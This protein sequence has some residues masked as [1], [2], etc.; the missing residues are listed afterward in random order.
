MLVAPA[1]D[2]DDNE[3]LQLVQY[4][5]YLDSVGR[6]SAAAREALTEYE[7]TIGRPTRAGA[8]LKEQLSVDHRVLQLAHD[9]IAAEFRSFRKDLHPRPRWR[10]EEAYKYLLAVEWH[11]WLM[12][13]V[14]R[15]MR[16]DRLVRELCNAMAFANT[17][18]GREAEEYIRW[19]MRNSYSFCKGHDGPWNRRPAADLEPDQSFGPSE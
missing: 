16:D 7:R 6:I 12:S 10:S 13:Q 18:T 14:D 15:H 1:F 9:F 4:H 17:P 19:H 2:G 3:V 8:I 11:A 5:M